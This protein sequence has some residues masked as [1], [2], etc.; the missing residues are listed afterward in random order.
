[1]FMQ[2]PIASADAALEQLRMGCMARITGSTEMNDTSS[3]S[4]AVYTLTLIQ[5][6]KRTQPD[7]ATFVDTVT[8]MS[9][10]TFVDLAGS[11]RY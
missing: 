10:F 9:K 11:E 3:R 1:M 4:H 8:T 6:S 2:V 5:K 7:D